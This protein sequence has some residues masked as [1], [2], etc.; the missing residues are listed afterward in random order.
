[1]KK[2][3]AFM[4]AAITVFSILLL[5]AAAEGVSVQKAEWVNEFV[6]KANSS[7][8]GNF[9][10]KEEKMLEIV[11]KRVELTNQQ[12]LRFVYREMEAKNVNIDRLVEKTDFFASQTMEWAAKMGYEVICEYTAYEIQGEIV[13]IDPLIV[14]KR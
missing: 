10:V 14:I 5:P 11:E 6:E 7:D 8:K 9:D 2:I 13:L 4:V 12:I 1:M 3:I